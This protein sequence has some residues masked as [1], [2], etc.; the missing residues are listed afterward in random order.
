M[1][2]PGHARPRQQLDL[3]LRPPLLGPEQRLLAALF[4]PQIPLRALRAVIRRVGL[5]A[6]EQD[7]AAGA[8]LAQPA[9]AVRARQSA[10]DQQVVDLSRGHAVSLQPDLEAFV[11]LGLCMDHDGRAHRSASC[12]WDQVVYCTMNPR[13][14][15]HTLTV[16]I[17]ASAAVLSSG[18]T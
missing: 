15:A 1:S 4:A 7:L 12:G 8:F 14:L 9:R 13:Q 16:E 2:R 5:A 6:D 10:A 3:L 18:A 17:L 11:D